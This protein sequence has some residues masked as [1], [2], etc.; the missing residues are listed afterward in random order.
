MAILDERCEIYRTPV[1]GPSVRVIS[2][3][4]NAPLALITTHTD[5]NYVDGTIIRIYVTT[6]C[7]ME[8]INQQVTPITV[9]SNNTFTTEIDSSNYTPF[10]IPVAPSDLVN[11][12]CFA[13]PIGEQNDTLL[14]SVKNIL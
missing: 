5:H 8:Q 3:I 9:T 10:A 6:A 2:A 11:V 1:F 13:T 4:S 7:G 14:A 12:C